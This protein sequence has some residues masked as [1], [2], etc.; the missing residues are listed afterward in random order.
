VEGHAGVA[1][2]GGEEGEVGLGEWGRRRK[3]IC[4]LLTAGESEGV[5]AI[6]MMQKRVHAKMMVV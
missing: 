5:A 1:E 3:H 2:G 4:S 6:D